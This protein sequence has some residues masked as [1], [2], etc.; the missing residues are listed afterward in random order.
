VTVVSRNGAGFDVTFVSRV[1]KH[2]VTCEQPLSCNGSLYRTYE[3]TNFPA[4]DGTVA[5][6]NPVTTT[7]TADGTAVQ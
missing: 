5:A 1:W 2:R 3:V 4:P 6:V 7:K